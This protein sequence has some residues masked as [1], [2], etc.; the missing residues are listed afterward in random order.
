LDARYT[1]R[2]AEIFGLSKFLDL[3]EFLDV[4]ELKTAGG[5]PCGAAEFAALIRD[6]LGVQGTFPA[7]RIRVN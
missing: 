2:P 5:I 4:F 7:A 1:I 6:D 3:F